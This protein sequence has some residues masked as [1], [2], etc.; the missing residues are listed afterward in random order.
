MTTKTTLGQ[1]CTVFLDGTGVQRFR[2]ESSIDLVVAGDL[3]QYGNA[4]YTSYIFVHQISANNDPKADTF[5]R[6]GNV[7]DLTTLAIGRESAVAKN[8]TLYL[9]TEFAVTYDDVS[10]ASTAKL[11]I[12]QRVDNL[13]ADWHA[14]QEKFLAPLSVPPNLSNISLPLTSSI[15]SERKAAYNTAHAALLTS[16][17]AT[18]VAASAVTLTMSESNTANSAALSAVSDSQLCSSMLGQLNSGISALDTYRAAVNAFQAA[19]ALYRTY[20][21]PTGPQQATFDAA[22]AA[23]IAASNAEVAQCKPVLGN[24]QTSMATAC[25]SKLSAVQ[26]AAQKKVAADAAAAVALTE[27]KAAD[28]TESAALIADTTAYLSVKELCPDFTA[29]YP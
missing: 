7:A 18:A 27:K 2:I 19:A 10:T 25:T 26:I 9:A 14:Y 24:L 16:K 23:M 17:T 21:T 29:T 11:L 28:E 20:G 5:L 1:R 8:Q 3:P 13:I 12:Q 22:Y 15:E 4:P 6:V